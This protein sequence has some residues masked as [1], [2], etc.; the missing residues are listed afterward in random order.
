MQCK[1]DCAKSKKLTYGQH[2]G[3][4]PCIIPIRFFTG[5]IQWEEHGNIRNKITQLSAITKLPKFEINKQA[6]TFNRK[7]IES[8]IELMQNVLTC[9]CSLIKCHK[10]WCTDR[11]TTWKCQMKGKSPD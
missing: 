10:N 5:K 1:S 7:L 6:F 8:F 4:I 11:A 9:Y 3:R 2:A